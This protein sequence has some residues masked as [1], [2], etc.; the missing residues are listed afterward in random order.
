[1][2]QNEFMNKIMETMATADR[3]RTD[4]LFS[5]A[6]SQIHKLSL[7]IPEALAILTVLLP[8]ITGLSTQAIRRILR[9]HTPQTRPTL[10]LLALL[11]LQVIYETV[12]AT[13]S[14][15][16][17]IPGTAL[18]CGLDTQWLQL[19]RSKNEGAIRAI[20][21]TFRCC[22][23][24]TPVDRPWPFPRGSPNSP[25]HI[26]ADQC[27][28]LTGTNVSC[29]GPWRQAEQINAGLL[30]MVAFLIFLLKVCVVPAVDNHIANK[31]TGY[32]SHLHLEHVFLDAVSKLDPRI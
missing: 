17:M 27:K 14:L 19:Y 8:V 2:A 30:L 26:G 11:A 4:L 32:H 3:C 1:M 9:T 24:N 6:Y 31:D 28:R 18:N 10:L 12:I 29:V 21:D 13:L 15:T 22:G 7:P 25:D 20:Q 5:Y 16:H 23:L